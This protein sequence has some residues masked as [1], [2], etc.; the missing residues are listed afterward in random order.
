MMQNQQEPGREPPEV[1]MD[2]LQEAGAK[3]AKNLNSLF[4]NPFRV[5][6]TGTNAF[7]TARFVVINI[8]V[9]I[10]PWART[11]ETKTRFSPAPHS[12]PC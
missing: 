12:A 10:G 1:F 8:P 6:R 11:A 7:Q 2:P 4:L 3:Q 5:S 9:E